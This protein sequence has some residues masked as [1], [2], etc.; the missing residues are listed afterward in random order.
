MSEEKQ[1]FVQRLQ[2]LSEV[3]FDD[4]EDAEDFFSRQ[5]AET[6][7]AN[8]SAQTVKTSGQA[9]EPQDE[10]LERWL[11]ET[12]FDGQLAVDVFQTSQHIVIQSTIAGVHPEDVD[13]SFHN[14]TLTIKGLRR[15]PVTIPEEDYLY[16]ECYW[17]GF[18]R[19]IILPVDVHE[20]KIAAQMEN[21]VLTITIPKK[22][23]ADSRKIRVKEIPL[24]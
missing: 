9:S 15:K 10:G 22:E 23:T 20:D 1:T 13:I 3:D 16:S 14:D 17:G 21:G 7:Q 2:S 19:S 4:V 12:S 18:S 24:T 11:S 8:L 6:A 5:A